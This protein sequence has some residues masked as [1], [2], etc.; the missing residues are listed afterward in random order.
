MKGAVPLFKNTI[1]HT[2]QNFENSHQHIR[3]QQK[4]QISVC[5]TN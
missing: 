2:S 5:K 4:F 1:K 3:T